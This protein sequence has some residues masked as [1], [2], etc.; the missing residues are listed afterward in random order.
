MLHREIT[1]R[2]VADVERRLAEGV[3]PQA[4]AAELAVTPYVAGLIAQNAGRQALP[5]RP[6]KT[7][8]RIRNRQAC[9]E[10]VTIR[11]IQR[12]LEV[13]Q[14]RH[15]EIA[16]E[17]GVSVTLVAKVAR[18]RRAAI[19]PLRPILSDGEEF[20][21]TPGRCRG[22]GALISVVPCR[23][24]RHA[25]RAEIHRI[26]R[27]YFPRFRKMRFNACSLFD[28]LWGNSQSH[29]GEPMMHDLLP[30]L[31]A[32]LSSFLGATDKREHLI[33]RSEKLFD[34]LIEPVDLPGPDR[35]IDPVLRTVIRP[36][37]GR[38]YDEVVR[39]LE[40]PAHAA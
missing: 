1:A 2:V 18:G 10:A 39:K 9:V 26:F 22:C 40:L 5:M 4:V 38:L 14:L 23:A 20:L 3:G 13:G 32:E 34:E 11:R 36:L 37:V 25:A 28:V 6:R 15:K 33:F 27:R 31:A 16:R 30:L 19:T 17:A 12:M 29:H 7:A 21:R 35:I 24:C 8:R